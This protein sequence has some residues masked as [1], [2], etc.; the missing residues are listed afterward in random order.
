MQSVTVGEEVGW[1]NTMDAKCTAI[2]FTASADRPGL[3]KDLTC[4]LSKYGVDVK[5]ASVDQ[6]QHGVRHVYMCQDILTKNKLE[7]AVVER[8]VVEMKSFLLAKPD[9]G[10]QIPRAT[11]LEDIE[12]G[13]AAQQQTTQTLVA[14]IQQQ[15]NALAMLLAQNT[16][17]AP[18]ATTLGNPLGTRV[19]DTTGEF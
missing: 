2:F 3:M 4:V 19:P 12:Q 11:S 15:N 8:V 18:A 9:E 10:E 1:S 16:G 6:R 17:A 7:K 5:Q 14:A 13:L